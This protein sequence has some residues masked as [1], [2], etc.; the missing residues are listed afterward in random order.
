MTI[1]DRLGY[2]QEA[3]IVNNAADSVIA[4][5][6]LVETF[7]IHRRHVARPPETW[8]TVGFSQPGGGR[9]IVT[10]K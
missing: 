9:I 5:I 6:T 1:D 2:A 4:M 8:I 3:E 10:N 7:P